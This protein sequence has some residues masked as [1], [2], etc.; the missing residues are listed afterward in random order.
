[1]KSRLEFEV[2]TLRE[3]L[4]ASVEAMDEID[5]TP[6]G[7]TRYGKGYRDGRADVLKHIERILKE[8]NE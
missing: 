1:M 3:M 6:S 2:E 5:S 4:K 8:V 7:L